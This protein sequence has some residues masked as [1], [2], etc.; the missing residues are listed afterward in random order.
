MLVRHSHMT[1]VAHLPS[2]RMQHPD[3]LRRNDVH[4]SARI[5]VSHLDETRLERKD[6]GVRQRKR[7]GRAFPVDLPLRPGPPAVPVDEERELRVV[8]EELAVQ[9]LDVDRL[10][11]FLHRNEV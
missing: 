7:R 2:G 3:V 9:P 4:A 5:Y 11:V 1:F 8:E 10:G 6:V